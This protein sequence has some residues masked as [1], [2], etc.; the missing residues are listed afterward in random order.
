MELQM[1]RNLLFALS[2]SAVLAVGAFAVPRVMAADATTTQPA[3]IDLHNTKCAVAGDDV[4]DSKL[5]AVYDGKIYHFC[6]DSCP[7]DFKKDPAKYAKL[8]A[9]DPAKYG[10]KNAAD[11]QLTK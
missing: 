8:V 4:G 9:A 1:K 3:P 5:T 10:I 11:A 6:C 2:L 7:V